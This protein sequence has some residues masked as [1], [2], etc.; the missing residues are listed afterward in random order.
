MTLT[1][2]VLAHS[3]CVNELPTH[4]DSV[5]M[6]QNLVFDLPLADSMAGRAL[7]QPLRRLT[8]RILTAIILMRVRVVLTRVARKWYHANGS[9][10]I[11]RP[12]NRQAVD[13]KLDSVP[14]VRNRH[15]WVFHLHI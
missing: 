3:K 13:Q 4:A 1:S 12:W 6:A 11:C 15:A 5:R 9:G 14:F 2:P 8:V 7:W 10:T